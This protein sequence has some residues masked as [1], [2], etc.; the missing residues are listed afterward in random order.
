MTL[1]IYDII[2]DAKK[3]FT[4]DK[5][6]AIKDFLYN[7]KDAVIMSLIK[8]ARGDSVKFYYIKDGKV[9]NNDIVLKNA[10]TLIKAFN[11]NNIALYV[12]SDNKISPYT[13]G[14][15]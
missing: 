8:K 5:K 14:D 15:I 10:K 4:R 1:A 3:D 6:S 12:Y 11:K 7:N 9:Q 13:D 2:T